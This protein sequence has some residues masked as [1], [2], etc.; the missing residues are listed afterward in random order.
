MA[1]P[2]PVQLLRPPSRTRP[3]AVQPATR[4]ICNVATQVLH[5]TTAILLLDVDIAEG[6]V[7]A[8]RRSTAM[9]RSANVVP[10]C[11]L[12]IL[13]PHVRDT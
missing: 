7:L 1:L 2:I 11:A 8:R 6:E 12:D 10:T 3:R 4:L 9:N 13:P 5:G